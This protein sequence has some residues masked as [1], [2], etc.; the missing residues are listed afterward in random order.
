[1]RVR[2]EE[3]KDGIAEVQRRSLFAKDQFEK[4]N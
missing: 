2:G 3:G 4:G 1:M